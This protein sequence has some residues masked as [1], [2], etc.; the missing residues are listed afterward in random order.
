MGKSR[1]DFF[2]GSPRVAKWRHRHVRNGGHLRLGLMRDLG[3]ILISNMYI[4]SQSSEVT[5]HSGMFLTHCCVFVQ[6]VS[7]PMMVNVVQESLCS[8][9]SKMIFLSMHHMPG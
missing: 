6:S 8:C 5:H 7:F 1:M 2:A 4:K 9:A 3:V